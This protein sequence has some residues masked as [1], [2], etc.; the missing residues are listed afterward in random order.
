VFKT[1]YGKLSAVL[2]LLFF[3]IGVLFVVLTLFTTRVHLQETTQKLNQSLARH[4]ASDTPLIKDGRI[5]EDAIQEV[6]HMLMVVHP[7]IEVYLLDKKGG[8]LAY[9][10]PPGKVKREGVSLTP[11]KMFLDGE[12][13]FPI[14]GDDPRSPERRKVFSVATVPPEGPAEGYLYVI[15]G[16]EEYDTVSRMLEGSYIVKLSMWIAGGGVLFAL[17]AGLLLF[18]RITYRHR[19]LATAVEAFQQSGFSTYPDFAGRFDAGKGDEIERLGAAFARMANRI[20]QQIQDLRQADHLRR[21]LVTHVSHDLRTPLTSLQGYLETLSLK[22]GDLSPAEQEEYL[23]V[24]LSHCRRLSTLVSELFEL[25]M[26]DSPDA[27]IRHEPFS[28]GDLVQD[29]LQKFRLAAEEKTILLAMRI[30][31]G[32]PFAF[33]DIALVERV[34]E[35]LVGNALRH[36]P[37]NGEISIEA[38]RRDN[39][40]AIRVSDTGCGIPPERLSRLFDPIPGK[41]CEPGKNGEGAGLGLAIARRILE[42]HGSDLK[43]Q[44]VVEAGSTF[45]FTLPEAPA[46]QGLEK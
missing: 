22:E 21:E 8:I 19:R 2:L 6:F 35:N 32:I 11:L 1:L 38:E 28:V 34:L 25:S 7:G 18:Y 15:L 41:V 13:T 33:G 3:G 45:E 40:L 24:A 20:V 23:R 43:V 4:I 9:S 26:L 36:T 37:K 29:I 42:L 27:A 16:G 17:L 10:A 12:E 30:G 39:G 31:E 44:S 46:A 14:L 5:E